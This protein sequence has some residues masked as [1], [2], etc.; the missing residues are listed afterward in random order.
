[1]IRQNRQNLEMK[2]FGSYFESRFKSLKVRLVVDSVTSKVRIL[3]E[4]SK[5]C[6][7]RDIF[8][9]KIKSRKS[10]NLNVSLLLLF[11]NSRAAREIQNSLKLE[12]R[13]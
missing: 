5:R 6:A 13:D 4:S 9:W 3:F 10:L 7:F 2:E 12:T 11:L 1:M 8:L